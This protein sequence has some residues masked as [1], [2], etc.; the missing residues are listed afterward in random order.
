MRS[1]RRRLSNRPLEAGATLAVERQQMWRVSQ[2][3]GTRT[4]DRGDAHVLFV[5]EMLDRLSK[6]A[7]RLGMITMPKTN[8]ALVNEAR[9]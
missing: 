9:S 4:F 3:S 2:R 1:L 6:A 5:L 7:I 8:A